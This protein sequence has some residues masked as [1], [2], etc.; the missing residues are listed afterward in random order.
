MKCPEKKRNLAR[1]SVMG[2]VMNLRMN[3]NRNMWDQQNKIKAKDQSSL[4]GIHG[5]RRIP[6]VTV[7]AGIMR[8][9]LA[10]NGKKRIGVSTIKYIMLDNICICSTGIAQW[11]NTKK[12]SSLHLLSQN[13]QLP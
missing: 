3:P 5:D 7:T 9:M 4:N 12:K 2:E 13:G 1:D 8:R 6:T 11:R 10:H